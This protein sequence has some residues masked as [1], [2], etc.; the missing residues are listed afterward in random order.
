MSLPTK[1]NNL[2]SYQVIL[3][4]RALHPGLFT[5]RGRRVISHDEYEA[6]AWIMPGAHLLRFEHKG[7]CACELV[8]DKETGLPDSGVVTTFMCAGERDFE[9]SFKKDNVN[10]MTTVQT[11][12]LSENLYIATFD[13]LH[14][15]ATE[16]RALTHEWQDEAGH[17][18]SIIDVQRFNS[19]VHAQSYHLMAQGGLVLRTQTIFELA[20]TP[21]PAQASSMSVQG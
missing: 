11:E 9:H 6:E 3:Y 14:E 2:Q 12:T 15:Y 5:L 21:Q 17:C 8:T 10:Y 13:E 1:P 20:P 4:N 16:A 18:L 19:E 7:L